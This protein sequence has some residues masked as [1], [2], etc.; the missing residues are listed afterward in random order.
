MRPDLFL[1]LLAEDTGE[2]L[3]ALDLTAALAFIGRAPAPVPEAPKS[4]ALIPL[5]GVLSANGPRY[6]SG[7]GMTGFR[8]MIDAAA[9]NK[10]VGAIVIPTDSPGGT[11]AGTPE[12]AAA[13]KAAAAIKPVVAFVDGMNASAAYWITS[14]ASQIWATPSADLGS[15]GVMG[16]HMEASKAL[17]EAGLKATIV[18]SKRAPYKNEANF[19]EPLSEEA[20]ADLQSRADGYEDD[21]LAAIAAGRKITADDVAARF[22][23]GRMKTAPTAQTAGMVDKVGSFADLLG[24]LHTQ[25]G[26]VRRRMSARHSALTFI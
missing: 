14:Q 8:A 22:G 23:Q 1:Q 18:R 7:T 20:Q 16:Q 17:D 4:I 15:I 19:F 24:S 9:A 3:F 12:T 25:A 26:Q 11:V 6:M 2:R 5:R 10:D 13:V 21:M